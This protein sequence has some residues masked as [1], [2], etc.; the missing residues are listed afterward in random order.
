MRLAVNKQ[1]PRCV[2][3]CSGHEIFFETSM[4]AYRFDC[5]KRGPHQT[6]PRLL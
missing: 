4:R 5:E 1:W 3:G 6:K 2:A